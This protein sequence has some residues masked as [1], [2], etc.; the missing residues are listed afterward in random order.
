MIKQFWDQRYAESEPVYGLQPNDFFK[1]FIDTHRPGTLLLP[2][3]GEGRNAIYAA[4][5]GWAVDAFDFSEVARKKALAF[6]AKENLSIHY[7]VMDMADFRATK[8]YDAIGLIYV[9]LPEAARK[10]FHQEIYQSLKTGGFLV[11][12]AFAKE[13]IKLESGGPRD[14]ALLYDAPGLCSDFPFLHIL[15]CQQKNLYL[16]EGSYHQGEASV[17]RLLGQHL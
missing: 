16:Q 6:A 3:E 17:L 7:S 15:N 9:H 14:A 8:K 13:Q 12:E 10:K 4:K 11:L 1:Q 2:A 5:K